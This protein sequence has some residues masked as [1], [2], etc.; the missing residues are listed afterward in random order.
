MSSNNRQV[1]EAIYRKGILKP[2]GRLELKEDEKVRIVVET[3]DWQSPPNREALLVKLR[4]GI[5]RMN[6]HSSGPYPSREQL[7]GR[8]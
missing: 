4:E 6:F 2:L 7:H 8:D 3:L 5:D 1:I